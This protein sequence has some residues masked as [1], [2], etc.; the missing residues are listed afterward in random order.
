MDPM[1]RLLIRM[2]QWYR[3]PPSPRV[4]AI[5]GAVLALAVVL[6]LIERFVGW[7]DWLRSEPV[8]VRRM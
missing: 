3:N 7:P 8:P 2:A 5:L 4:L 1:T 6:V